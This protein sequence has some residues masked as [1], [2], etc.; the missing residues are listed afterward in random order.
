MVTIQALGYWIEDTVSAGALQAES[1]TSRGRYS[2]LC[3]QRW[4]RVAVET[5]RTGLLT[6]QAGLA[7]AQYWRLRMPEMQQGRWWRRGCERP[8]RDGY[9]RN[10]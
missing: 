10:N 7:W 8:W 3:I 5:L 1:S 6:L 2:V 4:A 9:A